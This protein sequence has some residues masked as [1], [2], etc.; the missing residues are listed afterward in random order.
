MRC[1]T[2]R[3][4][5][6]GSQAISPFGHRYFHLLLSSLNICMMNIFKEILMEK[7]TVV[8]ISFPR[9]I[10]KSE[11]IGTSVAKG[12]M[13]AH[14]YTEKVSRNCRPSLRGHSCW[15]VN[16]LWNLLPKNLVRNFFLRGGRHGGPWYTSSIHVALIIFGSGLLAEFESVRQAFDEYS[17]LLHLFT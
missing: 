12:P 17:I 3:R 16:I 10:T 13:S 1:C 2:G 11:F 14:N 6:G 15:H 5:P 7:H 8:Q 4:S 9:K